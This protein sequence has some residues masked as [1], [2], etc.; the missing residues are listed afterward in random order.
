MADELTKPAF[1]RPSV[2]PEGLDWQSLLDRDG[3]APEV[4]YRHVLT[5]RGSA[6]RPAAR[7][8]SCSPPTT[9]SH[10]ATLTLVSLRDESLEDS[11]S[12]P[13]PEVIAA[14][15]VQDLSAALEE[16]AEIAASLGAPESASQQQE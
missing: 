3:D 11:D 16:F 12:L 1:G 8:A 5:E 7:V 9:T 4:H 10:A 13:P 15:I 14:E 2:A 6:T